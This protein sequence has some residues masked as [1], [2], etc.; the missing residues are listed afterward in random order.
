MEYT[1]ATAD[2]HRQFLTGRLV[3]LEQEHYG[4]EVLVAATP[5]DDQLHASYVA[6]RDATARNI[7]AFRAALKSLDETGTPTAPRAT[8]GATRRAA[9]R[10]HKR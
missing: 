4:L 7:E 9:P 6:Q 5:P 8:K 10:A 1:H 2:H 3:A